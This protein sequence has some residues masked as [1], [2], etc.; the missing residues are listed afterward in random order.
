[1]KKAILTIG[2]LPEVSKGVVDIRLRACSARTE[3]DR[4]EIV[5]RNFQS[6][7]HLSD[8]PVLN[9]IYAARGILKVEDLDLSLS[10]LLSPD[11]MPDVEIAANRLVSSSFPKEKNTSNRGL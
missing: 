3:E 4:M 1:M 11:E 9:R 6:Q 2:S 10:T 7:L 5:N 8:H